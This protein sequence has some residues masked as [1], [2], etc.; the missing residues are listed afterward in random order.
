MDWLRIVKLEPQLR[1]LERAALDAH[2]T[3]PRDWRDWEP[4]RRQVG[5]LVGWWCK[6]P[7]YELTTDAAY[8]VAYDH[9]LT[10]WETGRRPGTPAPPMAT[11]PWDDPGVVFSP[12][13]EV[14]R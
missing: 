14:R 9:L 10:C 5:Q 12:S 8:H 7:C 6:S 11:G 1:H 13:P 4:I 3:G 2:P